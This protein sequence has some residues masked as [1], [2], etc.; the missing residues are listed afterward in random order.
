MT[1]KLQ[2]TRLLFIDRE[3]RSGR[4]P[5]ASD[6]AGKYEVNPR[7]IQRDLEYMRDS[8]GAPLEY[9]ESRKGW[10]YTEPNFYLPAME[11]SESD[12]F[13]ICVSEKALQQYANTPIYGKLSAVFDK[14]RSFL[15]EKISVSTSWIDTQYTFLQESHTRIDPAIWETLSQGLRL[16]RCVRLNH[17]KAGSA[18][19]TLRTVDPYHLANFRGE[20][21]LIARCH[22]Q[23]DVRRFAISRISGAELSAEG[24]SIPEGFNFSEFISGSFGIMTEEK[25]Y[26]IRIWFSPGQAPYVLERVWH[27]E[28]ETA[29]QENGSVIL[30]FPSSS[31][32]ELKR[33]ILSWGPH[34]RVLEPE[35][36]K[37][38]VMEDIAG[39]GK[40][41]H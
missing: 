11:L 28:Q 13:A 31:L 17:K 14:I 30:S 6:I 40:I 8:L 9:D 15:P 23:K 5:S 1:S 24:F 4:L 33:W 19:S 22:K 16:S 41:Y 12:F 25:E 20:W 37:D 36:L 3:I 10:R 27:E 2:Y 7:T 21:Y 29:L 18:E 38:M 34:A 35:K 39:M 26:R 32:F